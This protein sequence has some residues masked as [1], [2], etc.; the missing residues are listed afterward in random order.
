[1]EIEKRKLLIEEE[2]AILKKLKLERDLNVSVLSSETPRVFEMDNA[3]LQQ[4]L[5]TTNSL[6][7]TA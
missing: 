7:T 2:V 6:D 5:T 1:M 3:L 4:C